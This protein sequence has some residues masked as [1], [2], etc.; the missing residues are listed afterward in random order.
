MKERRG[1]AADARLVIVVTIRT[2]EQGRFYRL[3]IKQ[4]LEAIKKAELLLEK[5][6]I[7]HHDFLSLVPDEQISLNE[8]RRISVPIYGITRWGDIYSP[9]QA[10]SLTKLTQIIRNIETKI[11]LQCDSGLAI[12]I[13]T[14]LGLIVDKVIQYNSSLCRWK[15]SGENLVDTFGRQAIPMV[16]DFSEANILGGASGDFSALLEWVGEMLDMTS[17]S[18]T[19]HIATAE[20]AIAQS[21]ILPDGVANALIT[22]PPI[23]TLFLM[24]IYQI[25]STLGCVGVLVIFM[26][27]YF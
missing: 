8:I 25:F 16:W 7:K 9:R 3:S 27:V 15:A 22:D 13:Q 4:D 14:C 6:I 18:L 21:Q 20:Q 2:K 11:S 10:L 24:R 23:M 12:A 26:A 1:G 19:S 5:L 17:K